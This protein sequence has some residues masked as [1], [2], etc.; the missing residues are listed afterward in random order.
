[1]QIY[2]KIIPCEIGNFSL[3]KP[4]V[5]LKKTIKPTLILAY[6]EALRGIGCFGVGVSYKKNA[7]RRDFKTKKKP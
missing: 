7:Y 4:G 2:V 6:Y 3:V 1:V 5:I